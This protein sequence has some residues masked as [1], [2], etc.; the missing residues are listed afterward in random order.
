LAAPGSLFP[1]YPHWHSSI[2]L[3]RGATVNGPVLLEF[4]RS[5]PE[6]RNG[7]S[8]NHWAPRYRAGLERFRRAVKERYTEGTL[9]RLLDSGDAEVRQAAVL[10]LG[11]T[12]S[13]GVN[14]SLAGRL[15]DRDASV[16]HLAGE[17]LWSLWFRAGSPE[18]NR[19]LRRLMRLKPDQAGAA[20][21]LRRYQ[22]LLRKAPDFAEVYNQ[23]A[24]LYFRLGQLD[25]A[26]ADC[27]TVLRL[28][29]YHFGA[30]SGM[31]HCLL[32]QKKLR[33]ALRAFRRACRI[34][35]YIDGVHEAIESLQ[36]MLDEGRR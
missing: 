30:A 23:R 28:N 24:I 13:M 19:E 11:L 8:A 10:G 27:V 36:R 15:R 3:E 4:Y 20:P 5:L 32:K 25:R 35:P 33:A 18:C 9:E 26:I 21:V 16:R 12:G 17:A 22:E 31:A 2:F 6:R 7:E 1:D 14:A 34:N 29:P